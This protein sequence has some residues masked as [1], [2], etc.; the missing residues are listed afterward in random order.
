MNKEDNTSVVQNIIQNQ[1]QQMELD[2]DYADPS[3]VS[4]PYPTGTP[5]SVLTIGAG[6]GLTWNTTNGYSISTS[7][8]WANAPYSYDT[9]SIGDCSITGSSDSIS[10]NG[11][12]NFEGD[13]T[14]KG[15]SLSKV[16]DTI[17]QRLGIL[18]P[19]PELEERWDELKEL[20]ERYRKLEKEIL[21]KESMW[22]IIKK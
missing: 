17:E 4:N 8:K 9:I 21:E 16:L 20:S 15:K 11:D 7:A 13:I 6:S 3:I 1:W 12:A 19:N 18:R 14:F 5:G 2:L 22:N 10:V